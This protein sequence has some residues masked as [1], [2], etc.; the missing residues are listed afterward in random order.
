MLKTRYTEKVGHNN[1]SLK[2]FDFEG[3]IGFGISYLFLVTISDS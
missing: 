3:K 1:N 2:S